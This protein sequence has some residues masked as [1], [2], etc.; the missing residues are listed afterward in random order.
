MRSHNVCPHI[1]ILVAGSSE[2]TLKGS[3][4][5]LALV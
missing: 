3:K 5:A 1:V 4:A 2:G